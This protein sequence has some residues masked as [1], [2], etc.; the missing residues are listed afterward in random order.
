MLF[1]RWI[2][3]PCGRLIKAVLGCSRLGA[4]T[5]YSQCCR[6]W[7][8]PKCHKETRAPTGQI[9]G[10]S[11]RRTRGCKERSAGECAFGHKTDFTDFEQTA[12]RRFDA[13]QV[14]GQSTFKHCRR[15]S[16]SLFDRRHA[17]R[18]SLGEG[19]DEGSLI[20]P[21]FDGARLLKLVSARSLD[22][23]RGR[24]RVNACADRL[25]G[26]GIQGPEARSRSPA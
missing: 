4:Q 8:R 22:V 12:S 24:D 11:A 23:G 3:G 1:D 21:L 17:G 9:N 2:G 13:D 6:Y 18:A 10:R 26:S 7:D 20:L 19:D 16:T 15:M 5:T 14:R 25:S